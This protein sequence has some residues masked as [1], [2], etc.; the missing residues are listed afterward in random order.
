[1][2]ARDEILSKI[3]DNLAHPDLRFPHAQ[4]APLTPATRMTVTHAEGD[5]LALA[6]RFGAELQKLHGSYQVVESP[7]EARMALI[8]QLLVW[9]SAEEQARKGQ[10]LETRQE[11]SVLSWQPD[12]LPIIGID[13]A[14][15]DLG[16]Q[17]VA[18]TTLRSAESREAIRFIR[19]GITG[20][21][22]AF[23]ST[24]SLIVPSGPATHRIASLLPFRHIALVPLPRLY[25]TM[26]SWL[27]EQ[28]EAGTLVDFFRK[29]ANLVMISGPSKSADIEMN[30][31][32]GVHGPKFVHV[33]LFGK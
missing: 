15:K 24:G 22:A 29:H 19:F 10:R 21:E 28:R 12:A 33:I 18:P 13:D 6:Q 26:E 1:L 30:L 16:F 32:L 5:K 25:P 7:A 31:T 27:Q 23:A 20:V 17:L 8:S 14:L 3:R 4:A 11:N 2:T 9:Q